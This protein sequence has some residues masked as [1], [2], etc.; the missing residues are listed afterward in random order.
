MLGAAALFMPA[1]TARGELVYFQVSELPGQES[2]HDSFILPLLDPADI[3][4]ARDLI[5]RGPDKAGATILNADIAAGADGINRDLLADDQHPWSWHVTHFNG[6]GDIGI[7]LLDGWPGFVEQDVPGWIHN[8]NGRIGFWN[9][10]VT[11]EVSL[12]PQP[13]PQPIP[14]NA[15]LPASIVMLAG[16]WIGRCNLKSQI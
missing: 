3:A 8:T 10:T 12:V 16:L 2:H 15:M 6:F 13:E 7:E 11:S 9:Y 1:A 5:S 4:H 14:L